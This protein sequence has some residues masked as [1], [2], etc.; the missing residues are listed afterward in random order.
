MSSQR[1]LN[2]FPFFPHDNSRYGNICTHRSTFTCS[3]V[4]CNSCEVVLFKFVST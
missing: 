2:P 3:K 1:Q 4:F